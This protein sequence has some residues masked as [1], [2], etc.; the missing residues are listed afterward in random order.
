MSQDRFAEVLLAVQA[1]AM[2]G[3]AKTMRE[4]RKSLLKVG[5]DQTRRDSG[6]IPQLTYSERTYTRLFARVRSPSAPPR[7][8]LRRDLRTADGM[9]PPPALPRRQGPPS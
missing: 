8:A 4:I 7:S 2:A 1:Y 3:N 5:F 9:V 6:K